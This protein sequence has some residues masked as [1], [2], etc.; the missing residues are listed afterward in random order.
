MDTTQTPAPQPSAPVTPAP[1]A[2]VASPQQPLPTLTV[3]KQPGGGS[4]GFAFALAAVF[5]IFAVVAGYMFLSYKPT[6]L[7]SVVT[8]H[9]PSLAPTGAVPTTAV[10]P[11]TS[12]AG[13][14]SHDTSDTQLDKDMQGIQNSI[15]KV[16]ASQASIDQSLSN[17]SSDTPPSL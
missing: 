16:D 17:Q 8:K 2:P 3:A 6:P 12:S 10:T 1:P 9:I 14:L 11:A 13:L 7:P 5:I 4:K 15:D